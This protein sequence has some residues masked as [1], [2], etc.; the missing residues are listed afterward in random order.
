MLTNLIAA[1]VGAVLGFL[2]YKFVGCVTGACAIT[3][4]PIIT[5]LYGG[6]LGVLVVNLLKRR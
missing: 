1:A 5:M 6:V 4:N 2:Y 3:S